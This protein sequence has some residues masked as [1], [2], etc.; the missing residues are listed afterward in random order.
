[1]RN[2]RWIMWLTLSCSHSSW[3]DRNERLIS[4]TESSLSSTL[5]DTEFSESDW[6]SPESSTVIPDTRVKYETMWINLSQTLVWPVLTRNKRSQCFCNSEMMFCT[7][8]W[9]WG[10]QGIRLTLL[11]WW[12]SRLLLWFLAW[13]KLFGI[14]QWAEEGSEGVAGDVLVVVALVSHLIGAQHSLHPRSQPNR[15][16]ASMTNKWQWHKT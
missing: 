1:M 16:N 11:T 14:S 8:F 7:A 10:L 2:I 6:L 4:A 12:F 5:S 3:R 13:C 15:S 9:L